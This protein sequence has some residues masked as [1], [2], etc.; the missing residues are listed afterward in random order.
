M[1]DGVLTQRQRGDPG[2]GQQG[3]RGHDPRRGPAAGGRADRRW[4]SS[5][6]SPPARSGRCAGAKA[7]DRGRLRSEFGFVFDHASPIGEVVIAS[8]T[9]YRLEARFRGHAAHAGIRPEAGRNAIAAAAASASRPC[10]SAASTPRPPSTWGGSRAAPRRTWWPSAVVV[11]LEARSLDDA[12]AGE[13]V[14][15]MVD[16]GHR[17]GER[18][19]MRRGDRGRAPVPRA[20]GCRARR[21]RWRSRRPALEALRHR[22]GLH[23]HRRRQRRQR[24]RSLPACRWSTSP[25][26]PSATT[27]PTRRDRRGARA[28]A[29]RDAGDRASRRAGGHELRAHR[30]ARRPGRAGSPRSGWTRFRYDDG[31]E[32][33]REIVA[34]PGAV[35]IAGPRRRA[36][37]PRP[38]AARG[39]RRARPAGAAGGQARR[40]GGARSTP[41]SAS[42]PRRSARAPSEWEH[43]TSFYTSPGFA[44]E[45][46]PHLPG[47]PDLHDEAAE[48]DE[49][50]RIEIVALPLGRARRRD[51]GVPRLQDARSALLWLARSTPLALTPVVAASRDA[52][53]AAEP[54]GHGHDRN[55]AR[56]ARASSSWC[57]TSSP[58]SS[59]SAGSRATRSRPTGPT[60]SSTGASSRA[61]ACPRSTP[62]RADVAD[63]LAGAGH[64]RSEQRAPASPATI[65]RKAACLRSFYR[66]LR[67]EG[68]LETDPTATLSAPRRS[69]KLPHVLTPRRGRPAAGAARG[70]EPAALRDRALLELMYACGLRASEAIG[71]ERGRRG[72]RGARAARARQGLEGARGADRAGGCARRARSYLERGPAG[73]REGSPRDA[74]VRQLPRGAGSPGRASTRS[75]AATR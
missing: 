4:A 26:A 24:V 44:D 7:F 6:C 62:A 43:L 69:R 8:P 67:R 71:L 18:R 70:S 39:R 35:A 59:S 9:Y 10:R 16:A 65:H 45:A 30:L 1:Q 47:R 66:H 14:S 61:G 64:G 49:N 38:P 53:A 12:R 46:V 2:R 23:R 33:E 42:S 40:G 41:P 60:C 15:E 68:L 5:C 34:H 75:C 56:R 21:R 32:A 52:G 63:F 57:S 55:A 11:E 72:P 17:G 73:P 20:T 19:R 3:G 25:T 31:E 27:S 50:E 58:T 51:R 37:V 22:A 74:A 28:D 13:V 48:A 36:A 54:V 29:R